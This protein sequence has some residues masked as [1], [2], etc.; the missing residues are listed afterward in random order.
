MGA[1]TWIVFGALAGW[2]AT[3]ISGRNRS[4]GCLSNILLGVVG[5]FVGGLIMQL[6]TRQEFN[7]AFNVSSFAVA[8][9]GALVLLALFARR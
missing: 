5:A 6:L 1:L 3:R 4:Q 7:F 9:L 2:F 8:V